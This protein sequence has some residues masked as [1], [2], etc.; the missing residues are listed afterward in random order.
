VGQL[1]PPLISLGILLP[2][3]LKNLQNSPEIFIIDKSYIV[4]AEAQD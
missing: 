4:W 2:L 1:S 3:F